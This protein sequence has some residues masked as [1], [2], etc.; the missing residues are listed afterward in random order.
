MSPGEPAASTSMSTAR[1]DVVV[2]DGDE[3][4]GE[5]V[6]A[7]LRDRPDPAEVGEADAAVRQHEEVAGV[8]V[9]VEEAVR[10][11]LLEVAVDAA[12]GELA[13]VDAR[14]VEQRAAG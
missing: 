2:D 10:E 6:A 13:A 8:R 4:V 1:S 7:D 3:Q 14:L 5:L 12:L 11:D 9:G